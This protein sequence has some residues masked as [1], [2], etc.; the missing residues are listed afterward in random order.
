[1]KTQAVP[2][3]EKRLS[4]SKE[5]LSPAKATKRLDQ[6][7]IEPADTRHLESADVH[8]AESA[9]TGESLIA[10]KSTAGAIFSGS[11]FGQGEIGVSCTGTGLHTYV[12]TTAAGW[13]GGDAQPLPKRRPHHRPDS[14]MPPNFSP[15][16]PY[17]DHR[18]AT[19]STSR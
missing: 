1:L 12:G 10:T 17:Q 11:I 18:W 13:A 16:G 3:V 19:S 15:V 6:Y 7:D 9:V 2:E 8:F 4:S 14:K 5:G